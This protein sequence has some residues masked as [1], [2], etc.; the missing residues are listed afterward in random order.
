MKECQLRGESILYEC[1]HENMILSLLVH[2]NQGVHVLVSQ[3][4]DGEI[5][6]RILKTFGYRTVR[7]SSTRG[8]WKAYLEMKK[9][10]NLFRYDLAFTPDGPRGP[11][12][13]SKLGIIRLASETGAPIIPVGVA[14]E[15]FMRLNSWDK[16]FIIL[17]FSRCSLVYHK[18]IYVPAGLNFQQ[19]KEY[20]RKLNIINNQLDKEAEKCLFT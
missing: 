16:L 13:A 15:K 7:G 8:G 10:M 19:L 4:F 5:I 20:G 14:A 17:P 9:R 12:R 6:A 2:A 3:H 11:R 1:W 18:P